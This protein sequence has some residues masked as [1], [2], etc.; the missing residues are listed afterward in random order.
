MSITGTLPLSLRAWLADRGHH[1]LAQRV[2]GATFLIR[3]GAAAL[4]Y[5]V[6]IA[7][8]R[9]MGAYEFGVYVYVWTWALLIGGIADFGLANAAQRFIPQYAAQNAEPLLRGFLRDARRLALALATGLA[10]VA[11]LALTLGARSIDSPAVIPLY[12]A[13]LCL[14][15]YALSSVQDGIAR[16]YNWTGIGLVPTFVMRPVLL[17]AFMAAAHL[18]GFAASATMAIV[19]SVASYWVIGAAQTLMLDRRLAATVAPGPRAAAP[20]VWLKTS[21]PIMMVV[22]FYVM[23]TYVDLIVLQMFRAPDVVAHYHAAA[24]TMT[25]VSFIYFSV[26]AATA[27]RFSAYQAAGDRARLEAFVAGAVRWTFWPSLALTAALL[28]VGRPMLALFGGDF[29]QAYPLMFVMAAGLLARA[30]VGPAERLLS[31]L[32]EQRA[33]AMAYGG[34]FAVNLLACLALVPRHGA[35]GAAAATSLAL[36]AESAALFVIARRRLGLHAFI[37]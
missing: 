1:A 10:V 4:A 35:M 23:L 20:R 34:A 14:P 12:L 22:G 19:C 2:A 17:V 7:L 5:L 3:V 13:C 36:V 31:M 24:K 37:V 26:S 11:A 33:C 9:W 28:A 25:L 8:A 16:C 6:Q 32:G 21:L 18:A 27:H 15:V 30:S 29:A